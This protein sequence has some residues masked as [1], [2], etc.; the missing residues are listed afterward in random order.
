MSFTPTTF[1][2]LASGPWGGRAD[3][4]GAMNVGFPDYSYPLMDPQMLKP[5]YRGQIGTVIYRST[6]VAKNNFITGITK[7]SAGTALGNC[8]VDLFLTSSD[9]PQQSVVSDAVGAFSFG[10]PGTGPFYMV[11]YLSGAPDVAGTSVNTL[12]TA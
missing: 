7:D 12:T 9:M 4:R 3:W 5:S 10:N 6:G 1:R 2:L 8:Q 11:A